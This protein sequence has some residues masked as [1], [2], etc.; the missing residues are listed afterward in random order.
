[1]PAAEALSPELA[2]K[3]L[4]HLGMP[5]APPPNRRSL[6]QL[7]DSYTRTAPW[8]SASRIVRRSRSRS[9]EDCALLGADFWASHLERGTGGTCYESNYAFLGLLRRIGYQGYLT[10]NDMGSAIGCHSAIVLALDGGKLLVDVGYPLYAPLPLHANRESEADSPFM[11]YT[12]KPLSAGRYEIW[13]DVTRY[14]SVF[15]LNDEAVGEADYRAVTI[16]DYRCDGGQFLNEVVI[17]KLVDG[18]IWRFN[19]AERPLRLQQFVDGKRRDH[20][21]GDGAAGQAAAKFGIDEDVV[22]EAL[23]LVGLGGG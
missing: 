20:M 8:E 7:L 21:L 10:L 9:A 23:R 1:M 14:E 22:A 18:H 17:H 15:Q 5:E 6:S 13:R 4:R 12:A 11:R 16:Y 2:V 19:S 3:V